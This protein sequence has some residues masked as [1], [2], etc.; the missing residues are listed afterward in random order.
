MLIFKKSQLCLELH[1]FEEKLLAHLLVVALILTVVM[2]FGKIL[3]GIFT[4]IRFCFVNP[5][6]RNF[7][8]LVGFLYHQIFPTGAW[9]ISYKDKKFCPYLKM[10]PLP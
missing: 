3:I 2:V 10:Y 1:L 7:P 5:L 4:F 8:K 6:K 9:D